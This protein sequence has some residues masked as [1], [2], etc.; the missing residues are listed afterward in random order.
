MV[1]HYKLPSALIDREKYIVEAARGRHVLHVGCAD[2]P[3]TAK[4]IRDGSWL[5]AKISAVAGSCLGVDIDYAAVEALKVEHQ[6]NDV[7]VGNAEQLDELTPR[8]FDLIVAGELIE[9]LNNPGSFLETAKQ[10]LRPGGRL[11][12]STTNAFCVRR[13]LRIPFGYESIH[14]D[15]T[16]YFSH[17]TLRTLVCRFGYQLIHSASYRLPNSKPVLPYVVE[18]MATWVS[19]NLGEGILHIYA[20]GS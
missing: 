19:P 8:T 11:L 16:Y 13:I 1:Q 10:V 9:H 5:H 12:I 17:I 15:H 3:F 4:R 7:V 2:H 20:I 14:P 18:R 6:V